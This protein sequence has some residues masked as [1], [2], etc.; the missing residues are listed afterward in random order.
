MPAKWTGE[1]VGAMHVAGITAK[2]LAHTMGINEKYL[3]AVLN[4]KKEPK[5]AEDKC[6]AALSK[7]LAE[8]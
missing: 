8:A 3:S 4:G 6:K 7:L 2:Q 1:V 5:G